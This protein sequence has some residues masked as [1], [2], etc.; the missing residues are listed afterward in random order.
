MNAKTYK[1][2]KRGIAQCE[3]CHRKIKVGELYQTF[4]VRFQPV[5]IRCIDH[6][7]RKSDMAGGRNSD[8]FLI[9]ENLEDFMFLFKHKMIGGIWDMIEIPDIKTLL[10]DSVSK[11]EDISDE[12]SE[13]ADNLEENSGWRIQV[14][15]IQ[16]KSDECSRLA[17][18]LS[19]ISFELDKIDME[20]HKPFDIFEE[21]KDTIDSCYSSD[22]I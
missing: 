3:L 4:T 2:S 11:L 8:V 12:Y 15:E 21:I 16:Q 18:E 1:K 14:E 5:R 20:I 22:V 17:E 6:R 10:D 7:F 9:M 19:K 13:S